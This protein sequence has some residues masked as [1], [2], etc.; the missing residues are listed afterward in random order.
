MSFGQ[1]PYLFVCAVLLMAVFLS[2][3]AVAHDAHDH[4]RMHDAIDKAKTNV[5]SAT[6]ALRELRKSQDEARAPLHATLV[7]LQRE[8]IALRQAAEQRLEATSQK[9]GE[10]EA[11]AREVATL[12]QS[13]DALYMMTEDYRR[14][15]ESR[16]LSA[17]SQR[18]Q[19]SLRAIDKCLSATPSTNALSVSLVTLLRLG[20]ESNRDQLGGAAFS[21]TCLTSG[22]LE[23]NGRFATIGP[24]AYFADPMDSALAGMVV[25]RTGSRVPTLI[26]APSSLDA[27]AIVALISGDVAHIPI[28]PSGGDAMMVAAAQSNVLEHLAAG[29]V[30]IIP[31]LIIGLFASVLA[32]SKMISL[33]RIRTPSDAALDGIVQCIRASKTDEAAASVAQLG[34]PYGVVLKAGLQYSHLP[35]SHLE[36]VLQERALA[37]LPTLDRHLGMLAVLGG[38]SPLLGLLGTVTGMMY[39][40][41]RVALFGT[42]DAKLLSGGISEALVTT[43]VGLIIAVP[44]LIV[45]AMLTRR[46]RT[47]V[48]HLEQTVLGFMNR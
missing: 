40:F 25:T 46:V 3:P 30:I 13:Y 36:E 38:V 28:D 9:Q 39:T 17:V 5:E 15:F 11:M 14:G 44:I 4:A 47:I 22:G 20:D 27:T 21:G 48:A 16:Q 19:E 31:L 43:E 35:A 2:V 8:T 42:G 23:R 10:A 45:H 32:L 18:Y 26:N 6:T 29:G 1:R 24:L 7:E 12:N 41:E 37:T 33:S 34:D